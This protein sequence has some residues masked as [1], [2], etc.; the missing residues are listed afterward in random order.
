MTELLNLSCQGPGTAAAQTRIDPTRN[1]LH[2]SQQESLPVDGRIAMHVLFIKEMPILDGQ[3]RIHD[4]RRNFFKII[5]DR[6]RV[7]VVV[8]CRTVA[9]V[10]REA[11][12]VLMLIR[13]M[14]GFIP[15]NRASVGQGP[16]DSFDCITALYEA[17]G[18]GGK[19]RIA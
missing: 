11:S 13:C 4:Q 8:Q 14:N 9:V 5:V 12:L 2:C 10:Q 18:E 17:V 19:L 16:P 6:C 7:R 3:Q 15:M 1:S